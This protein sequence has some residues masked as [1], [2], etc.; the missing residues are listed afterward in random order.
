MEK[1]IYTGSFDPFTNG[2][3]DVLIQALSFVKHVVVGIGLNSSKSSF[4]TFEE[5]SELIMQALDEV[6]SDSFSRVSVMSFKGLAIEAAKTV[7]AKVIVRGLRDN[8]DFDYEMHMAS[9]NNCLSPDIQ[10]IFLP[11]GKLS[12][13]ITSNVVRQIIKMGGNITAFTPRPVAFALAAKYKLI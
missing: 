11:A 8:T 9:V 3:M 6:I 5:R 1:A 2:H 12:R 13:H 10:T 4:L 7:E